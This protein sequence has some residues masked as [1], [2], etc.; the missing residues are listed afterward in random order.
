MPL[1]DYMHIISVD[2]HLIEHPRVWSDRLPSKYVEAGPQIIEDEQGHHVWVYEGKRYP[3]I[4]LNAVAGKKFEDFGMEPVRYE[5]M[6]PGCYDPVARVKDMD[7][8]GVQAAA[9][10][11]SFPGFGGN[12]FHRANDKELALACVKAWNDFSIDEWCGSAPDRYIPLG[13]LPTWDVDLCVQ[14]LERIAAKGA[15]TVSFPDAPTM[16]GM[17]SFHN[18]VWDPFWSALEHH[19]I[20]LSLHFGSGG[21]VPGFNYSSAALS[22]NPPAAGDS[23]YAVAIAGFA[24]NLMWSTLDWVFSGQ[25][26]KHPDLRI[27]LSEGGIGWL[28]Y[29]SER[30][31]ETWSR[32]RWY[33]DIDKATDPA[34][35]IRKHFYGCFISDYFGVKNRHEIG[36]DRLTV[37]VDYPHS[38]SNWPNSRK[39]LAEQ[40]VDVP[41]DEVHQMVELNAREVFRF[42]RSEG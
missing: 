29:I 7:I 17:P 13:I 20:P 25:L 19:Q 32:H 3:Y 33:Q 40:F 38:D 15:R 24:T 35:L 34:D 5:D 11:P 37:E 10:F 6:I 2:D 1:Q 14:E 42:P 21:Y 31:H 9:C 12:V 4:G 8:D 18:P 41:D 39:I 28:P 26:Q 27:M 23:P 36:I 22:P 30:A 16:L